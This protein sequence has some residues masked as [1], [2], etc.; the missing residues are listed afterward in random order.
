MK[1]NCAFYAGSC[2]CAGQFSKAYRD[3]TWRT[4]W[5][6]RLSECESSSKLMVLQHGIHALSC[7]YFRITVVA[8]YAIVQLP[9]VCCTKCFRCS[10]QLSCFHLFLQ[11]C[12][13]L[14][15]YM[16]QS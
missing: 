4:S 3:C 7:E 14:L 10:I 9:F 6:H 11:S 1:V 13:S 5:Q 8:E 16:R 12:Y 15:E 2:T